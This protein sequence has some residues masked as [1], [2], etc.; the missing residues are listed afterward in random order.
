MRNRAKTQA[1]ARDGKFK[2]EDKSAAGAPSVMSLTPTSHHTGVSPSLLG[3]LN[4]VV[5]N[6]GLSPAPDFSVMLQPKAVN[7]VIADYVSGLVARVRPTREVSPEATR[8]NL[9]AV[10]AAFNAG[11][12]VVPP[13]LAEPLVFST[14]DDDCCATIWPLATDRRVTPDEMAVMLRGVHDTPPPSGVRDWIDVRHGTFRDR[15]AKLERLSCGLPQGAVSDLVGLAHDAIDR[16]EKLLVEAPKV[17]LHGDA[18]PMNTVEMNGRIVGCDLDD[19]CVGPIEA[20]LS[21]AYVHAERYPGTDPEM[22]TRLAT[23]YGNHDDELLR[24]IIDTRTLSK[25]INLGGCVKEDDASVELR[26]TLLQRLN[27]FKNGGRFTTLYGAESVTYFA[28]HSNDC[29]ARPQ[30]HPANTPRR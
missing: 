28:Q 8:R 27:A 26:D 16:L 5:K 20:D 7:W 29:S 2:N 3:Q 21:L 25:T 19:I 23:A 6:A 9:K 12:P 15:V 17:L 14:T 13:I 30:P 24:A 4:T 18:H 10:T 1:R 22:G 11:A